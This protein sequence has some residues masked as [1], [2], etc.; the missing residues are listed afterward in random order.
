[1]SNYKE[2]LAFIKK[3]FKDN[4]PT[5]ICASK[6]ISSVEMRKLYEE[7]INHFAENRTKSLLTKKN[8]L[9]DL[10]DFIQKMM[11]AVEQLQRNGYFDGIEEQGKAKKDWVLKE[12][13]G[14]CEKY[15]LT[16]DEEIVGNLSES[17]IPDIS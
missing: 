17:Y 5:I 8:E 13:K 12:V 14:Y 15:G 9:K 11:E 1:M 4:H 16:F 3:S 10:K 6:Y 7:G 2:N